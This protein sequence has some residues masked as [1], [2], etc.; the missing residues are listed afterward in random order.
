MTLFVS[1][2]AIDSPGGDLKVSQMITVFPLFWIFLQNRP[3]PG[4]V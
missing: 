3:L 1:L 2:R 4:A